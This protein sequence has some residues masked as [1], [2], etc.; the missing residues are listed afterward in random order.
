MQLLLE[1]T[2]PRSPIPSLEKGG[3]FHRARSKRR[4][5]EGS[6]RGTTGNSRVK[7]APA[8]FDLPLVGRSAPAIAQRAIARRVGE[9]PAV[10]LDL[11]GASR[12]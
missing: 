1:R 4:N 6:F 7:E 11:N 10:V 9:M 3:S 8:P 5:G 2:A 12:G